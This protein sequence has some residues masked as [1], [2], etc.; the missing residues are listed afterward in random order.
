MAEML[1]RMLIDVGLLNPTAR[2][3]SARERPMQPA[4]GPEPVRAR[5][6]LDA[7]QR[8][9]RRRRK[10]LDARLAVRHT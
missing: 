3:P 6:T 9:A 2:P 7:R 5:R 8:Q 1:T 10:A 4:R